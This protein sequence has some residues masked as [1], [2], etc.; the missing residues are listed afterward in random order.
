MD[1]LSLPPPSTVPELIPESLNPGRSRFLV[2]YSTASPI[3]VEPNKYECG[4]ASLIFALGTPPE[5]LG[6]DLEKYCLKY[7][8]I[9]YCLRF[10]DLNNILASCTHH[11][12][13]AVVLKSTNLDHVQTFLKTEGIYIIHCMYIDIEDRDLQLHERNDDSPHCITYDAFRRV[14]FINPSLEIL[15]ANDVRDE[16][17]ILNWL[18]YLRIERGIYFAPRAHSTSRV[19][20]IMLKTY[21]WQR[22]MCTGYHRLHMLPPLQHERNMHGSAS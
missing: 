21:A 19:R 3:F 20:V 15:S 7:L 14:L 8:P 1:A 11:G 17:S 16:S 22:Q 10:S 18:T 9:N 4:I 12:G 2:L 5:Q 6:I 13:G